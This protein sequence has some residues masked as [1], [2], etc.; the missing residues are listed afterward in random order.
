MAVFRRVSVPG[1]CGRHKFVSYCWLTR[2]SLVVRPRKYSQVELCTNE[3]ISYDA[4]EELGEEASTRSVVKWTTFASAPLYAPPASSIS[5]PLYAFLCPR[6]RI[7]MLYV[8]L[9]DLIHYK[10]SYIHFF[11]SER[12]QHMKSYA[13]YLRTWLKIPRYTYD[14]VVRHFVILYVKD[15]SIRAANTRRKEVYRNEFHL[16][17][18]K[19]LYSLEARIQELS[20]ER[21]SAFLPFSSPL[22]VKPPPLSPPCSDN[23]LLYSF[24]FP[25]V[26]SSSEYSIGLSSPTRRAVAL[27]RSSGVISC[28]GL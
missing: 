5:S 21:A 14:T 7:C 19:G 15:T 26:A 11:Q 10:C 3:E 4:G 23:G 28:S 2:H 27:I 22:T 20:T 25:A 9:V 1:H 8:M 24:S 12:A 13:D 17:T 16:E 6:P 18:K